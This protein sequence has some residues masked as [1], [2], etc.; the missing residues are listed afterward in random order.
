MSTGRMRA[1]SCTEVTFA[2]ILSRC[3]VPSGCLAVPRV[4]GV[5]VVDTGV[6]AVMVVTLLHLD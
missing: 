5:T 4:V 2:V 6:P 1:M 3:L